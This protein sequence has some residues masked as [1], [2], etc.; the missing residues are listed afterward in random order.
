MNKQEEELFEL[1]GLEFK[2][3]LCSDK[4]TKCF[5]VRWKKCNNLYIVKRV[6]LNINEQKLMEVHK[7]IYHP[8]II[9]VYRTW[10]LKK[11][12]YYLIDY[13]KI[14]LQTAIQKNGPLDVNT[15]VVYAFDML[16]SLNH[17]HEK[18]FA[19]LSLTPKKFFIDK[20]NR[21]RMSLCS[22]SS[23][24]NTY[25]S[26]FTMDSKDKNDIYNMGLIFFFMITGRLIDDGNTGYFDYGSENSK[27]LIDT[28]I[29]GI[30]PSDIKNLIKMCLNASADSSVEELLKLPMFSS[31][32]SSVLSSGITAHLNSKFGVIDFPKPIPVVIGSRCSYP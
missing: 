1:E 31:F 14:N 8:N 5:L 28:M 13:I 19:D 30:I 20:Y 18:G 11:Y 6:K 12:A 7:N 27:V 3:V 9:H 4:F 21:I 29:P 32:G 25:T 15:F 10:V 23:H 26:T 24:N 17:C 22:M 16:K 2:E